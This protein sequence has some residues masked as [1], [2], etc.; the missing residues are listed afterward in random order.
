[1]RRWLIARRVWT[2]V[3]F[4]G[5]A[6]LLVAVELSPEIAQYEYAGESLMIALVLAALGTVIL[7]PRPRQPIGLV[8]FALGMSAA[9]QLALGEYAV[10][11]IEHGWPLTGSA[12]WAGAAIRIVSNMASVSSRT[13]TSTRRTM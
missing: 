12:A 1:M 10:L 11:G 2:G 7:G 4:L 8:L 5:G 3:F 9:T 13:G 6:G